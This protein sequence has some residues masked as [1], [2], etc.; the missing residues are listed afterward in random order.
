M[1]VVGNEDF[2]LPENVY[3]NFNVAN[4]LRTFPHPLKSEAV[5][6]PMKAVVKFIVSVDLLDFQ[7]IGIKDEYNDEG[8]CNNYV[9]G[10]PTHA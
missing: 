5:K 7:Y 1:L 8:N 10:D 2:S 4:W 9:F 6:L 3:K